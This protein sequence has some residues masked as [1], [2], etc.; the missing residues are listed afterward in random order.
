MAEETQQSGSS[1]NQNQSQ[2]TSIVNVDGS[3]IDNWS[4]KYPETDRA[5]LSRFKKFDDLV[6]SHMSMRKKFGKNPDSLVEIPN[7]TS[8]DEVKAAFHKARGVPD[9]AEEYKYERNTELS[10]NIKVDDDKIAAFSQI[11]KSHNLTP[12][13]FNGVVNDYLAIIDKDITAF[14]LVQDDKDKTA[15][16]TAEK[17]LKKDFGNAYDEKI[18]RANSILRKYKGQEMVAELNL[19]NNPAMTRFLDNIAEDMSEDRIKDLHL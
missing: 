11:A 14:D 4:D 19:E 13:Q 5:T 6:T 16:E 15:L 12:I 2:E 7:E 18:A 9:T 17:E 3:F 10:E 8:T 1:E